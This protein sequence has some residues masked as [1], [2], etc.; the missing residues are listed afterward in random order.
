[1]NEKGKN[2]EIR[3]EVEGGRDE[4][5]REKWEGDGRRR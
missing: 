2:E 3:L 5:E 1:M 4:V